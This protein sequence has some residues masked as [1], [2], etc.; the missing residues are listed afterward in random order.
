MGRVVFPGVFDS[1]GGPFTD[2]VEM[3]ELPADAVFWCYLRGKLID[4]DVLRRV[5]GLA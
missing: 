3:W 4:G 5:T 1:L 2:G